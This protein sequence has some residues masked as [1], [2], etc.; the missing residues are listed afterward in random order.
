MCDYSD[1]FELEKM[2]PFELEEEYR[3]RL[4]EVKRAKTRLIN[5]VMFRWGEIKVYK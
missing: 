5:I 1:T 4:E 3:K 2:T